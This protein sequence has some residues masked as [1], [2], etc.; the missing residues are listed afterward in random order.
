MSTYTK[1][2]QE[3]LRLAALSIGIKGTYSDNH[4]E[5]GEDWYEPGVWYNDEND[6]LRSFNSLVNAEDAFTLQL[7]LNLQVTICDLFKDIEVQYSWD[8]YGDPRVV[9]EKFSE[10]TKRY[11]TMRTITRAAAVIGD[12][13]K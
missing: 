8:I 11:V 6:C 12:K 10:S 1:E 9:A 13:L 7:E 2:D 4:P 5:F 3:L